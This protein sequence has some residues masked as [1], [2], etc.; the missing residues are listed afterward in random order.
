MNTTYQA[1]FVNTCGRLWDN[2]TKYWEEINC[3]FLEHEISFLFT[4]GFIVVFCLIILCKFT[5]VQNKIP[6]KEAFNFS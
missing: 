5:L 2:S 6:L 3:H 4:V 1:G